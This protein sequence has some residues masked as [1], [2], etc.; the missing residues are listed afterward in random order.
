M[1][2]T[3]FLLKPGG[4]AKK[5]EAKFPA[6]IDK[7][8][9]KDLKALGFYKKQF[10]TAVKDIHLYSNTSSNVTASGSVTYLYILG[11]IALFTLLIA[12]VNFMNLSTARSSKRSAEVGVRKVLGAERS[13]LVRQFLGESL[14]MS[15][16]AFA[17]GLLLTYL[18][19]PLFSRVSGKTIV[20]SF[21]QHGILLFAFLALAIVTGLVAGIYPAFYLSSFQPIKVL[22]GRISN[23]LAATSLRK[24]L[25]VF[26]FV[27]SA[28]LIIAA[29]TIS[30]QMNYLR[31]KDLGFNKD[32][33][34]VIPLRGYSSKNIY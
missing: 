3:Y 23:S 5:L 13:A 25:V 6:F 22:K 2:Y 18:L 21:Q 7:Y 11:S 9:G 10:L 15:M 33:Q 27:I 31:N 29:V 4:D 32:Q 12:C 26:Q 20:F 14:L 1:F 28:G 8:A 19:L 30:D 16:L 34:I 24:A 17:F